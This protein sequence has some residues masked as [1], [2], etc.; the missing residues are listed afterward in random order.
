V[1]CISLRRNIPLM[2]TMRDAQIAWVKAVAAYKGWTLSKW[3]R[4]TR[5]GVGE[6]SLAPSTLTR[7]VNDPD[8][9]HELHDKTI[10][11]LAESAG[12]EP[13]VLPGSRRP[14][15]LAEPDAV[16]YSAVHTGTDDFVQAIIED[17]VR[18]RNSL[19]PLVMRTR[20]LEHAGYL[21]G[22]ILIVD[23]NMRPQPDDVV[24]AQVYDWG[25]D[26]AETVVRILQPPYLVAASSDS[27]LL[28]P[29]VVDD[30]SVIIKGVVVHSMRPRRSAA[31]AAAREL[32]L[33]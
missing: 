32:A 24:C 2:S 17:L 26:R 22:D 19:T 21:P 13:M 31:A 28:K 5:V 33:A 4:R 12:I 3:A 18:E 11:A 20:S 16:P 23:L 30:E 10:E 6:N 29:L 14:A 9:T 25:G 1:S 15:N 7:F 27:R 8:A